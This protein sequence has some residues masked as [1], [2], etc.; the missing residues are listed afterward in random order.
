MSPAPRRRNQ[1]ILEVG[2]CCT[3][4]P[5]K[6]SRT[7][8][9]EDVVENKDDGDPA[10]DSDADD[11]TAAMFEQLIQ[12][13]RD[14]KPRRHRI[15]TSNTPADFLKNAARRMT[16]T[17]SPHVNYVAM[18]TTGLT[19]LALGP[20]DVKERTDRVAVVARY[21]D[22][23]T[24]R[25]HLDMF[26]DL[27]H[28]FHILG[29]LLPYLINNNKRVKTM[30]I[31]IITISMDHHTGAAR[32]SD[33]N[34]IKLALHKFLRP[35]TTVDG[36]VIEPLK[37]HECNKERNFG[38]N[39]LCTGRLWTPIDRVAEFD[40]NPELYCSRMSSATTER[41]LILAQSRKM[42]P[43]FL[44]QEQV[45][46][47][48]DE[49]K[50]SKGAFKSRMLVDIYRHLITGPTSALAAPGKPGK[51]CSTL[52]RKWHLTMVM[53]EY[54]VYVASLVD[55][56]LSDEGDWTGSD[57]GGAKQTMY[58]DMTMFVNVEYEDYMSANDGDIEEE[59]GTPDKNLWVYGTCFGDTHNVGTTLSNDPRFQNDFPD[60]RRKILEDTAMTCEA[61]RRECQARCQLCERELPGSREASPA[62]ASHAPSQRSHSPTDH[63]VE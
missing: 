22:L 46:G 53:P 55:F 27:C 56:L 13:L 54:L 16:W 17:V 9:N 41:A 42:L 35:A 8:D 57:P 58:K 37:A 29:N 38:Y 62:A 30:Q 51:G 52:S 20:M 28:T 14:A 1:A 50:P 2:S 44:F 11:L 6:S 33:I 61:R 15:K 5:H 36:R 59:A 60:T 4:E 45:V 10:A 24:A 32:S 18:V 26:E 3:P 19:I 49:N 25:E 63:G 21:C 23:K 34:S 12:E 31:H 39:S 43:S 48:Y 7:R 40:R 47:H